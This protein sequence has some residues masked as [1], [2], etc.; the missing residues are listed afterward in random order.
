MFCGIDIIMQNIPHIQTER[1]EFFL[2]LQ[3]PHNIVINLNNGIIHCT[4]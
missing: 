1:E 2:I 4:L 3:V